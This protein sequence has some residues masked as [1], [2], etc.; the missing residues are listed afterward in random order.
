ME[1]GKFEFEDFEK[2][3]AKIKVIGVGGGG[4]NT[5]NTMIE[6]GVEGVEFIAANTDAKD[7]KNNKAPIKLQIG[8]KLTK[9]LG[10]GAN[11]E[12]GRNAALEDSEKIRELLMDTDMLFV[13]AG[14]GGGTGTGAAPVIAS[15][16]KELGILTVGVVTKPFMFE[17]KRRMTQAEKGISELKKYVDALIVIPNQRIFSICGKNLSMKESF[18]M[19]DRVLVNAV[20]GITDLITESAYIQLDFAD[21]KAVMNETGL[22]L[23]GVGSA[24]GENRA[25]EAAQSAISS[26]LL[27]DISIHGAKGILINITGPEDITTMEINDA[28]SMIHE[29]ADEN[30][31][32]IFG[33]KFDNTMNDEIRVT[34]IA[35]GFDKNEK[36]TISMMEDKTITF[37]RGKQIIEKKK[38][39]NE[40]IIYPQ[41]TDIDYQIYEIPTVIRRKPD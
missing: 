25:V 27:E 4:G 12:V 20:R 32:I 34:I 8:A 40:E 10:A 28:C 31:N 16:A 35:T 23:M 2:L 3:E 19:V 37:A 29:A 21:V 6:E 11:P 22:A 33:V 38:E 30:A 7:L 18:K 13:T 39:I 14:M 5:V 9:G 26:P 15:I 36:N 17:G 24:K 1:I 41:E